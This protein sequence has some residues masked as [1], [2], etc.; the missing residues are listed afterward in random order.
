MLCE[1][2]K[3][4]WGLFHSWKKSRGLIHIPPLFCKSPILNLI[5]FVGP[6]FVHYVG[7]SIA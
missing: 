2:E 7:M 5:E 4:V 3:K 1:T 6:T